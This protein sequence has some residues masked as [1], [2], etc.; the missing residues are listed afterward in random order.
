MSTGESTLPVAATR[1]PGV[2]ARA[3]APVIDSVVGFMII[4]LPLLV[5][6]GK[7]STTNNTGGTTTTYSSSDPKVLLFWLALAIAYY[8]VFESTIGATPGK[9]LLGLRVR[10]ERG[11]TPTAAAAL[12]RNLF[13]LIDAFPYVV[14][15]LVGAIAIWADDSAPRESAIRRRRRIGDRF[16]K[17]IVTYR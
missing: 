2:G 14:P 3:I 15:Y 16:A 13:R 12:N 17:T 4:G 1:Y 5:L 9:L 6:F 10:D 8:V 11:S 7:K